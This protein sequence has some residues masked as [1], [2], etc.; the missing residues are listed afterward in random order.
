MMM[1]SWVG[2]ILSPL[3][4]L[5]DQHTGYTLVEWTC[6]GHA[7]IFPHALHFA[8]FILTAGLTLL[9]WSDGRPLRFGPGDAVLD[10]RGFL[11][12][13]SVLTGALA[14]LVIVAL[15]FPQWVVSPCA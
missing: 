11:A 10:N 15:W 8:F 2:L 1:Q 14:G 13:V 4:V 6:S 9:A 12:L 3:L 7:R 5:V